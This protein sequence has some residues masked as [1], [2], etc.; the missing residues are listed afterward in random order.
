MIGRGLR[1]FVAETDYDLGTIFAKFLGE[2][3][4]GLKTVKEPTVRQVQGHSCLDT[5]HLS[6]LA[7][8]STD[9]RAALSA[10][11]QQQ[12]LDEPPR[13]FVRSVPRVIAALQR[14]KSSNV[15]IGGRAAKW[16]LAERFDVFSEDTRERFRRAGIWTPPWPGTARW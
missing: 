8:W 12:P 6:S 1:C 16:N 10:K 2:G 5:E 3:N 4:A 7:S 14:F 15:Y 9:E 13:H 11:P